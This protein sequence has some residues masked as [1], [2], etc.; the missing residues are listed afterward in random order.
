M[1]LTISVRVATFV[2]AVSLSAYACGESTSPVAGIPVSLTLVPSTLSLDAIGDTKDLTATV[3]DAEGTVIDTT[4]LFEP[5]DP[6]I[7]TVTA[8]GRVTATGVG[9][10]S[11]TASLGDFSRTS[12]VKLFPVGTRDM[13]E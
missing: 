11:V 4:V 3:Y 5:S 7:I 10:A 1:R 8:A 6:S 12:E 9:V 13:V 2:S